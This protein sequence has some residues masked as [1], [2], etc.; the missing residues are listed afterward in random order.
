MDDHAQIIEAAHA[1]AS[2]I[3]RKDTRAMAEFLTPDFVYRTPGIGAVDL[4]T[5]FQGIKEISAEIVFVHLEHLSVDR[6]ADAALVTGVQHARVRIGAEMIDEWRPFVDWFVK[7]P[8]GK[9]QVRVALDLP[10]NK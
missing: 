6:V 9:W 7:S 3:A 4:K 2:A 10:E 5:F 8:F 1:I